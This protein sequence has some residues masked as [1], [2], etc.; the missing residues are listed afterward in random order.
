[1]KS[2]R[3]IGL[4]LVAVFAI[5]AVSAS[6]ASAEELPAVFKCG[7]VAK[8]G[9]GKYHGKFSDKAC[10]ASTTEG[11][12][13]L[14]EGITGIKK[15][16]FKGKGGEAELTTPKL[17]NV[18]KCLKFKD[19]GQWTGAKSQ[20][21]VVSIFSKCESL[22]KSCASAGAK[23]GEIKTFAL[24]GVLGY[25]TGGSGKVG[26]ELSPETGSKL[27]E[28]TCGTEGPLH[29]EA[30]GAVIGTVGPVNVFS[31]ELVQNFET[32]EKGGIKEQ[33]YNQLE[34]GLPT[35]VE[36]TINGEGP[37]A[38]AQFAEAKNKGEFLEIKA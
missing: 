37:F 2:M 9:D 25:I 27:A 23:S 8:G 6:A 13:E 33:K 3:I 14:E 32:V 20:G 26:V 24:K 21:K 18:V 28:F 29:L 10:S 16:E 30:A 5:A 36:T 4:A 7:K 22:G 15:T 19:S 1:M 38:S 35:T 31:K 11:K 34:G 12:Y 17:K